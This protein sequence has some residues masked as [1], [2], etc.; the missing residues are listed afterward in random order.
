VIAAP[1]VIRNTTPAPAS[2]VVSNRRKH[3]LS[4]SIHFG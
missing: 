2:A 4:L 3:S 1:F